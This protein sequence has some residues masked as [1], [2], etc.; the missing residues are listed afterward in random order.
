LID[1]SEDISSIRFTSASAVVLFGEVFWNAQLMQQAENV[2][3]E[4]GVKPTNNVIY[5]LGRYTLDEYIFKLLYKQNPQLYLDL[6]PLQLDLED[7]RIQETLGQNYDELKGA[8]QVNINSQ[9]I[10]T[11]S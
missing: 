7:F 3:S 10:T 9:V 5:V 6:E 1:L 4:C 2:I 11:Y 8:S